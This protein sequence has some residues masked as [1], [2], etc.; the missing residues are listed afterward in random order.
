MMVKL[1]STKRG[2]AIAVV[3]VFCTA[4]LALIGILL[5]NTRQQRGT[6]G[7]QYEQTRALMAARSGIQLAIY[8]YRVLPS[9]YYRIHQLS[10]DVKNGADPAEFNM[11][12]MMWLHDLQ[13][14]NADTPAAKIKQFLETGSAGAGDA[15][16]VGT[17]DFGVDEFDLVS[18]NLSGLYTQDYLRVRV[19]GS[20][21]GTRKTLEELVEIKIAE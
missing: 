1:Y 3:L 12:R 19:W 7:K 17:F 14:A 10:L 2:V 6:F 5:M 11:T 4:I 18:H 9:E 21:N 20:F 8:K 16:L 15:A 13:T